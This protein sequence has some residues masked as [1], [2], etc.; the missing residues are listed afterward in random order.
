MS[1]VFSESKTGAKTCSLDG[2][3]LHSKYNPE[4]EGERFA[5]EINADFSPLCI[6]ILEPALS[7]CVKRLRQRFPSCTLCAIRFTDDFKESDC[8]WDF[9]FYGKD[10][11]FY[12]LSSDL[13]NALGEE[14]LIS[15][16]CLDYLPTRKAFTEKSQFAWEEIKKAILKSRDILGTRKYFSKR[17]IKNSF[18]FALKIKN[19][20]LPQKTSKPVLIAASGPSLKTSLPFIKEY[21]NKFILTALSSAYKPLI[22]AGIEPDF[23]ISTDGGFWAKK[24]LYFSGNYDEKSLFAISTEGACFSKLYENNWIIPLVYEDSFAK[25]FLESIN[26][27]FVLAQRNGS[28]AGTALELM[29][30]LTSSQI[31][32]CGYDQ[33]PSPGIQHAQ[34]NELE[35]RNECFDFRFKPKETRQ[36]ASRF[37]SSASLEIYRNWF[38][39]KSENI[40]SRVERLS[41]NY[42]FSNKLGFIKDI[43]WNNFSKI[44]NKTK[45]N[46]FSFNKKT[47]SLTETERKTR[48]RKI[49]V[50]LKNS[51]DFQKEVFPLEYLLI[52]RESNPENKKVL[53]ENLQNQTFSFIEELKE[54]VSEEE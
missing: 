35:N 24:H 26:C 39:S 45:D 3:F 9:V 38:I 20:A 17:W 1:L 6:I 37:N 31:Y 32:L 21:R 51:E 15:S 4:A 40:C 13:Y 34:P 29:L 18:Q 16:L 50:E 11:S 12:D 30:N 43:N 8:L 25:I 46:C 41:D 44:I 33:A 7:Y 10:S 36:T 5:D 53:L 23:T 54:M 19:S 48:L 52:K 22:S 47:L 42:H 49:L 27:P 28:V 2:I 14:K